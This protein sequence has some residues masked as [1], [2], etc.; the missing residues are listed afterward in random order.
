M[1]VESGGDPVA[2]GKDGEVG[3][4]QISPVCIRHV[5]KIYGTRFTYADRFNV[6]K[7]KQICVLYLRFY[8]GRYEAKTGHKADYGVY[9]RMWNGPATW[10]RPSRRKYADK[11]WK[12]YHNVKKAYD[13]ISR[14]RS[15]KRSSLQPNL[16]GLH[17]LLYA[18][19][20]SQSKG[21]I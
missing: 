11:C 18:R 6:S 12:V 1:I 2:I 17:L 20:L 19:R 21:E 8:V 4:L 3:I 14:L 15:R 16:H 5:N 13:K 7:S 10:D 9:F